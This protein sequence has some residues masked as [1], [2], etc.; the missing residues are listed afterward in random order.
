MC[1]LLICKH[2]RIGI[3]ILNFSFSLQKI[4]DF[5]Y[6]AL[7]LFFFQSTA[8]FQSVENCSLLHGINILWCEYIINSFLLVDACMSKFLKVELFY[9][10][11]NACVM[12]V[13]Y[14]ISPCIC[15]TV[16]HS[17]YGVR[18]VLLTEYYEN[19]DSWQ[20]DKW[21]IFCVVL[22]CIYYLIRTCEWVVYLCIS[23]R[24]VL[25]FLW[26][27]FHFLWTFLGIYHCYL[28]L[29]SSCSF[30]MME[31]NLLPMMWV[32]SIFSLVCHL[33]FW[34]WFFF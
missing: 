1:C 22:I 34:P 11:I 12:F 24:A 17:S 16:L 28:H 14:Q 25:I 8:C 19:L 10:N 32:W 33:S 3:Y 5:T 20:S 27:D 18:S 29:S 30:Y 15:C 31:M 26:S 13:Y 7:Y 23:L 4:A 6:T 21:K 9:Q 2:I